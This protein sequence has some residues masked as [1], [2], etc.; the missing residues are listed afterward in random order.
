MKKS[1]FPL[2]L[3]GF[4]IGMTEFVTMGI[5]PD[6]ARSLA[7]TETQVGHLISIYALGVVVGA[8]TIVALTGHLPP[9]RVLVGLMLL[10]T[11]FNTLSAFMPGY[12]TL[13]L[14]RFFAGLPHGAFFGVGAVVASRL[15]DPGK[16]AAAVATMFAGLTVANLIGVPIGTHLGHTFSW[17]WTYGAIGVIGIATVLALLKW[18][19]IIAGDGA[20]SLRKEFGAFKK[21]RVWLALTV[22]AVGTGGLFAW[23]SYISKLTTDVAGYSESM[24][25]WVLVLSGLGMFCGNFLGGKLAD[26]IAPDKAT[27]LMLA[28]ITLT[29]TLVG[30]TAPHPVVMLAMTFVAGVASFSL[31]APIQMMIMSS[32]RGA[33]RTA[34][35]LGQAGFNIGNAIG[36]FA[37]GLAIKMGYGFGAPPFVGAGLAASGIVVLLVM[38]KFAPAEKSDNSDVGETIFM[39]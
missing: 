4:A 20:R 17:R 34:S 26:K 12:E 25:T 8:P 21:L 28:F 16:A 7:I 30:F 27:G 35:S 32:A 15:A 6:I 13:L 31:G 39:H 3:G 18:M 23:Y 38:M 37:G 36:A 33:E 11:V 14:A 19:P 10:F 29:L 22:T 9:R 2:A 1:L 5:L 24:I